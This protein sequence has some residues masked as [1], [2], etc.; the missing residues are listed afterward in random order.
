MYKFLN[1][2]D[3]IVATS[4]NYLH[5]SDI[6]QKYRYKVDVIPIGLD[7]KLYTS[8]KSNKHS[9][10]LD[11]LGNKFFLFVGVLR[12]YKGLHIL[13]DALALHDFW[14]AFSVRKG[15]RVYLC[16]VVRISSRRSVRFEGAGSRLNV[17]AA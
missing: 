4:P 17:N 7:K 12:Y 8:I 6:L 2:V 1:S 13:L 5:T 14:I 15:M 3:S 11:K 9:Y 16:F 10:W